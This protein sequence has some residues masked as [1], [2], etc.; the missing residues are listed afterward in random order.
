MNEY[1]LSGRVVVPEL[2]SVD[3]VMKASLKEMAEQYDRLYCR[4]NPY[5]YR[6]EIDIKKNWTQICIRK[7][8]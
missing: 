8:S 6:A 5:I 1:N 7:S 2:W 3:K 4:W